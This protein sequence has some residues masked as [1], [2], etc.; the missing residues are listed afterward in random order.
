MDNGPFARFCDE[1]DALMVSWRDKPVDDQL[2]IAEI[3]GALEF[4]KLRLIAQVT[5]S[6]G[7]DGPQV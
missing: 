2:S 3:V 5:L 1:L 6:S 4:M 7:G